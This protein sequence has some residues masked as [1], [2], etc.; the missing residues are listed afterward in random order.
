MSFTLL[1][2]MVTVLCCLVL[3]VPLLAECPAESPNE[4]NI[5]F[6]SSD[7]TK[8]P[9]L[10]C[11][12]F[13]WLKP[14]E[15]E[16]PDR[17][18]YP[19]ALRGESVC[20]EPELLYDDDVFVINRC[21]YVI[22]RVWTAF[23]PK[24]PDLYDTC[25][26]TIKVVDEEPPVIEN[27][28]DD[29]D[30]YANR[31][32]CRSYVEWEAPIIYDN[33]RV[34]SVKIVADYYG[35]T[36]DLHFGDYF[37]EGVTKVTY[38]VE[39]YC[40]KI[41][42]YTF[43]VNVICAD[44][45]IICPDDVS[46]PLGSDISPN[47][48]GYATEYEGNTCGNAAIDYNDIMINSDCSGSMLYY[49]VWTA[50]FELMPDMSF[51]CMQ[52]IELYSDTELIL[53]DCPED[54]VVKNDRTLVEWEAPHASSGPNNVTLTSTHHPGNT[55]PI[56]I[57]LVTYTAE[58][59]CGNTRQCSFKVMVQ[60]EP[61]NENCPDDIQMTCDGGGGAFVDWEPPVYEG[62]CNQ[63]IRGR[64]IPGFIYMGSFNGS[65]YYC[66]KKNYTFDAARTLANRKGGHLVS[67]NNAE[68]NAY[69]TSIIGSAT[70]MIGISDWDEEGNFVWDSGEP[71]TYTNWFYS[72]P[73]DKDGMQDAVELMRSG[74][75]NDVDNSKELEFV[76]EIPCQYVT[77]LEGPEPGTYVQS[78][79]Y[80][81]RYIIADGCGLEE[82]CEFTVFIEEGIW[83]TC[84]GDVIAE[85]PPPANDYAIVNW[86]LP[87]AT[88]CCVDCD[89][90]DNCAVV[91]Q[92]GGP[93]VGSRF[94]L[95]TTT[96][97]TYEAVDPCGNH[98]ECQFN[99]I[100]REKVGSRL[101]GDN[102]FGSLVD[103][104]TLDNP[105]KLNVYPNPVPEI[106]NVEIPQPDQVKNI[107]LYTQN[108]RLIKSVSDITGYNKIDISEI[109]QAVY[110][111]A[112][113]YHEDEPHFE[114][115]IKL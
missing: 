52:K 98:A 78:G 48:I 93:P 86:T 9:V 44:C 81:I 32:Q 5:N 1:P 45:H 28:P 76:M 77:Q 57:T 112:I 4:T 19:T 21:H 80:T 3:S 17:T 31:S 82:Y 22:T 8:P 106:L 23:D 100:V 115:V 95:G 71:V 56:G 20:D 2:R 65:Y 6:N 10:Q 54:I 59:A 60:E 74:E 41:S 110:I 102:D 35:Y 33:V 96:V 37:D 113:N 51:T 66:S 12:P 107:Q 114:R 15:S 16:H 13:V 39:D 18:G 75:W 30:V 53:S 94:A 105:E 50:N 104:N 84:R 85:L 97:I 34:K 46:L 91:S 24:H 26:Q 69:V 36:Y 64:A 27:G 103:R 47:A 43:E 108:G 29:I 109:G 67:I 90:R 25:H 40:D 111:L 63:C 101:S 89:S 49:R 42:T 11:A 7:C 61:I 79:L 62:T 38:I 83:L 92:T 88:A 99:V 68:E 73:N 70:A 55:F 14:G 87:E 72:Q 58:D